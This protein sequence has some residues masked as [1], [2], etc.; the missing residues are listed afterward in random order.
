[1]AGSIEQELSGAQ[2][3]S[4]RHLVTSVAVSSGARFAI[5]QCL[6]PPSATN[7]CAITWSTAAITSYA[8]MS[9]F[10]YSS[11]FEF[12]GRFDRHNFS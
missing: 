1:M 2:R 9:V 12:M 3:R 10:P 11:Q 8:A 4:L 5:R 6:R 7:I